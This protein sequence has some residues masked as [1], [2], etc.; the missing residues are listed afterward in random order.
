MDLVYRLAKPDDFSRID[1]LKRRHNWITRTA[2]QWRWEYIEKPEPES[3]LL[4]VEENGNLVGTQAL[5]PIQFRQGSHTFLTA[6]SEE[7]FL[8]PNLRGKGILG[9]MYKEIFSHV[10]LNEIEATW[11]ITGARKALLAAG[12]DIPYDIVRYRISL[13]SAIGKEEPWPIRVARTSKNMIRSDLSFL[14]PKSMPYKRGD[15]PADVDDILDLEFISD[16]W[17]SVTRK[18]PEVV[19]IDRSLAYL[20]WRILRNPWVKHFMIRYARSSSDRGY[21]LYSINN[22]GGCK[23]VDAMAVGQ[24]KDVFRTMYESMIH[25]AREMDCYEMAEFFLGNR[26]I[27]EMQRLTAMQSL[28]FIQRPL[29]SGFVYRKNPYIEKHSPHLDVGS[30]YFTGLFLE[31]IS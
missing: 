9:L 30:W 6:K 10:D 29:Y 22:D 16:V 12:F 5:L 20:R 24:S 11:G 3:L 17:K 4:M 13:R 8:V 14:S 25:R 2:T 21:L 31:G 27:L 7:T 1:E 15:L 28:L 19:S 18:F 26:C 23:V